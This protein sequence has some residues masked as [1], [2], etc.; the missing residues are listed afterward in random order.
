[1]DESDL[2][3]HYFYC[4]FSYAIILQL[5]SEYHNISISRRLVFTSALLHALCHVMLNS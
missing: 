3:T 1:M 2:I 4:G 5:L